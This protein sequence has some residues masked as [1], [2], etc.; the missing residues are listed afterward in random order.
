MG[1][2][3]FPTHVGANCIIHALDDA[4]VIRCRMDMGKTRMDPRLWSDAEKMEWQS[5]AFASSLLMPRM[6]ERNTL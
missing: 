6:A 5:N 4:T 1:G 2:M 3:I